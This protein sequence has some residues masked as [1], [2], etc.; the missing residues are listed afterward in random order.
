MKLRTSIMPR[1]DGTV[2]V[3]G[4]DGGDIVFQSDGNGNL[5]A[6]VQSKEAATFLLGL[7]TFFLAEPKAVNA[8]PT[9][10]PVMALEPEQ[11]A[12]VT[13]VPAKKSARSRRG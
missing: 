8:A 2:I 12:V 11:E 13:A 4:L 3:E 6:D 1:A 9:A 10:D 5:T 7:D